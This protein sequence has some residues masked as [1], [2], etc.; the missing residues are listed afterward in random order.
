MRLPRIRFSIR[1]M[2]IVVA[3][4]P[5][6]LFSGWKAK[7]LWSASSSAVE[8]GPMSTGLDTVEWAMVVDE[9]FSLWP[10][11]IAMAATTA[12]LATFGVIVA[13]CKK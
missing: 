4:T 13:R 9:Q 1:E 3:M 2:M 12:M 7:D 10:S 6:V 11:I 5:I 8:Q